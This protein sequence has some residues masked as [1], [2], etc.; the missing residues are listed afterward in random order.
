MSRKKTPLVDE[1]KNRIA[2]YDYG[3]DSYAAANREDRKGI[4]ELFADAYMEGKG[5]G[6]CPDAWIGDGDVNAGVTKKFQ[7]ICIVVEEE[8]ARRA[9]V[10]EGTLISVIEPSYCDSTY[11]A[12]LYDPWNIHGKKALCW[13]RSAKAWNLRWDG[14][15]EMEEDLDKIVAEVVG[16]INRVGPVVRSSLE[17]CVQ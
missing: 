9:K 15:A 6:C 13:F 1:I 5:H 8:A 14:E 4:R 10:P 11:A 16:V 3:A 17:A 12:I 2:R 7:H